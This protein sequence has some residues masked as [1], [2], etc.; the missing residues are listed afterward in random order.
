[1]YAKHIENHN[2]N[3]DYLKSILTSRGKTEHCGM[4]ANDFINLVVQKFSD[5]KKQKQLLDSMRASHNKSSERKP[6]QQ[7]IDNAKLLKLQID[8]ETLK[9]ET[10]DQE[11]KKLLSTL[12]EKLLDH[13][14]ET[15]TIVK[16]Q[17]EFISYKL[18]HEYAGIQ[19]QT[20]FGAKLVVMSHEIC[21][22]K[23]ALEMW[24]MT[25]L[26]KLG[27]KEVLVPSLVLER[28]L[29]QAGHLPHSDKDVFKTEQYVLSPTGEVGLMTFLS[30]RNY[31][32]EVMVCTVNQCYRKE[33][34]A[35]GVDNKGLYRMHEFTK[36]EM[37]MIA[38]PENRENCLNKLVDISY[39]LHQE[40]GLPL[41][42]VKLG[43]TE[44][45][46]HACITYDIESVVNGKPTEVASISDCGFGQTLGLSI[47]I[48]NKPAI[49]LNGTATT[50]SR[51]LAA[52]IEHYYCQDTGKILI[53]DV[54]KAFYFA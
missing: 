23:R 10:L 6:S 9:Y 51:T 11:L 21:A 32:D 29:H 15:N 49:S 27:F 3:F 37:V 2:I 45:G 16:K 8:V 52:I 35:H 26:T 4:A 36:C 30:D 1:M 31:S 7:Q 28:F 41:Q 39:Q 5:C 20:P 38:R 12:P 24:T 13:V 50:S 34:G 53:P 46:Q 43:K 14:P 22:L 47:T 40:L 54:L 42:I 18:Q 25:R 44:V 19:C 48:D 33:A 17:G